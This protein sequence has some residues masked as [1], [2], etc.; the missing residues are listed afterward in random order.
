MAAVDLRTSL[1]KPARDPFRYIPALDGIR[2]VG[3]LVVVFGHYSAGMSGWARGR[4]F[5][6]SLIIDLFFV[7][8]GYL[9][10]ALLLEEWSKTS[11]IS[12]RKFYVRRGLRLLP[13]LYLLLLF[14]AVAALFTDW[15]PV[16]TKLAFAEVAAAAFYIYPAI[17]ATKGEAAY[18]LHLWTLSI[19]EWF[20]FIWPGVLLA[21]GLR[22]GTVTRFRMVVGALFALCAGMMVL[23]LVGATDPFSDLMLRLRPDSLAYGALLAMFMRKLSDIRTPQIDTAL[24]WLGPAGIALL[25][26]VSAVRDMSNGQDFT[27]LHGSEYEDFQLDAFGSV[28]YQIGVMACFLFIMHLVNKP[29][30]HI[31][32]LLKFRPLVYLGILSYALYLWHQPL[33]LILNSEDLFNGDSSRQGFTDHSTATIWLFGLGVL[34]L[35]IAVSVLSRHLVELPALKQKKRF[36]PVQYEGKR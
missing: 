2:G 23:R 19:E 4:L 26:F 28:A 22:P 36:E 9:I 34:A 31:A 15:L 17:L 24:N 27:G 32:N 3:I 30:G 14:V 33:F 35:A 20:Y 7:L 29:D 25:V 11:T 13:A 16:S 18:L 21:A 5:G 8:S 6:L 10:T 1:D 12:L